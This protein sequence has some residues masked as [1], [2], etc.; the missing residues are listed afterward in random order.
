MS[1]K[2]KTHFFG[3][4]TVLIWGS[5]FPFTRFIGDEIPPYALAF[6]RC[7]LAAVVLVIIG[8]RCKMRKPFS[9]RDLGW[10]F[11]SGI[12]GFSMY[13][14]C[15]NK[16]LETLNS[17]TGSIITAIAPILVAVAAMKLYGERINITGWVSIFCAF[18]GVVVLLL[19]DGILSVNIGALWMIV[20]ATL[21]AGYTLLTRKLSKAGYTDIE[22]TTYSA[23]FG[24]IQTLPF[25]PGAVRA[26]GEA[27]MAA[28]ISAVYLGV[29]AGAVAYYTWSRGISIAER[30]S[31]AT[32][33]LFV[34]PL[35]AAI[36]GFMMLG[37]M[38]DM[39]TYIGGAMIIASVVVFSLKGSPDS[40]EDGV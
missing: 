12:C 35:I 14:I 30:T 16:G 40:V 33:Y 23:I 32:N 4:I 13:L 24:A 18:A 29:A 25:A 37:E 20:T 19:W 17:A 1:N 39:G 22:V 26:M 21:F 38:P 11:L 9:R 10:F 31:E 5:G 3:F 7:F 6:I 34:N 27:S 36:I 15:F 2:L 28:N 8:R